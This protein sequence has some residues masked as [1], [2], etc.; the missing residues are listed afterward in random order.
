LLRNPELAGGGTKAQA[1][2][3]ADASVSL[4]SDSGQLIYLENR[5]AITRASDQIE[6][7][8]LVVEF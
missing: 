5:R 6:D 2:V 1:A 8:K 3:Y 4:E 7:L